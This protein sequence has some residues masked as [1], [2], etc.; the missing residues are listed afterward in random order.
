MSGDHDHSVSSNRATTKS[1]RSCLI[2]A[3]AFF[4]VSATVIG[5]LMFPTACSFPSAFT[6]HNAVE[7]HEHGSHSQ[8]VAECDKYLR[9]W[10]NGDEAEQVRE[11]R[12][13]AQAAVE[14]REA[15]KLP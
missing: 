8:A 2:S 14:A 12:Q 4:G 15:A 13:A 7:A 3:V 1:T 9:Q 10:P 6:Y 5:V 11:L